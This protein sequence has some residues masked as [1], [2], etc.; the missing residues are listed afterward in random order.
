MSLKSIVEKLKKFFDYELENYTEKDDSFPPTMWAEIQ[1]VQ[2]EKLIS[3]NHF[4]ASS[5][6]VFIP[7]IRTSFN[8]SMY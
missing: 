7:Y 2:N 1:V 4:T 3:V 6:V 5:T 8:T